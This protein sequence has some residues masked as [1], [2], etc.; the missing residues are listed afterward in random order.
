MR[1]RTWISA[2][3]AAGLAASTQAGAQH[4]VWQESL[5]AQLLT[6]S[7]PHS[8]AVDAAGNVF[9]S[10]AIWTPSPY[11]RVVKY[12]GATGAALWEVAP[13]GVNT[14]LGFNPCRIAV[15]G[16]GNVFLGTNE[17]DE[18]QVTKL[19]GADG[20]TLWKAE[21]NSFVSVLDP[22]IVG[23]AVDGSGDVVVAANWDNGAGA[24]AWAA[25]FAGADG[26]PRWNQLYRQM[27]TLRAFT[28]D[29]AG[30]P[31]MAGSAQGYFLTFKAAAADGSVAWRKTY[32]PTG[33]NPATGT[34]VESLAA[35]AVTTDASGN[36][37]VT[38]YV[39]WQSALSPSP[40]K[41]FQTMKYN[42]AGT[43]LWQATYDGP[44]HGT[45]TGATINVDAQGDV[46]VTGASD[47]AGSGVDIGIVKH[48][49]TDGSVLWSQNVTGP[50]AGSDTPAAAFVD[51]S[52][53]LYVTG[54]TTPGTGGTAVTTVHVSGATGTVLGN[55]NYQGGD[56]G[57]DHG[58]ALAPDPSGNPIALAATYAN[59]GVLDFKVL[60]YAAGLGG[61]AWQSA[62]LAS[63]SPRY[64]LPDAMAL[65]A[66]GNLFVASSF[67]G[68]TS[69]PHDN[70]DIVVARFEGATGT[71][72]WASTFMGPL[73]DWT[74]G[75]TLDGAGNPILASMSTG[76]NG[77]MGFMTLAYRG[78]NGQPIWQQS[79]PSPGSYD[80]HPQAVVYD[81]AGS[82][83][84]TGTAGGRMTFKYATANGAQL[85][86]STAGSPDGGTSLAL[87]DS[88]GL[89]VT[90]GFHTTKLARSNG[91]VLWDKT[92][93]GGGSFSYVASD[94]S[95]NA[96]VAGTSS[97]GATNSY[98]VVKYAGSSGDVLWDRTFARPL[99][100]WVQGIK[101]DSHG[102]VFVIG[103]QQYVAPSGTFELGKTM[104]LSGSDGSLVWERNFDAPAV[105]I[106][107][108]AGLAVDASDNV[109]VVGGT[110][111]PA[112][113]QAFKAIAYAG[114]NGRTLWQH[115]YDGAAHDGAYAS[116]VA[117]ASGAVFVTGSAT[118]PEMDDSSTHLARLGNLP[119]RTAAGTDLDGNGRSDLLWRNVSTGEVYRIGMNGLTIEGAGPV[120]AEPNLAWR[121]VADADFNG[122]GIADLLWRND[123]TGE[124]YFMPFA[125]SGLPAGGHVIYNEANPAWKI[126]ATPDLDGDGKADLLWWNSA[127]GQVY[128]QLF[129]GNAIGAQG[130]VYAEPNTAWKIVATGDFTGAGLQSEVV[131]RN[132]VTGQL[133]M[134]TIAAVDG[135]FTQTGQLL[136]LE[137]N[138]A[139]K[140]V[141][142]PD[143]DGDGRAELLWHNDA[144]GQVYA[145][146]LDRATIFNGG[147]PPALRSWGVT[148]GD[149]IYTEPN[150]DWKIVAFG[151]Y[152]GDGKS[153]IVWRNGSDGRV[154]VMLMR[155]HAI[156]PSSVVYTEPDPDWH[157][158]GA[159]EYAH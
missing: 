138:T 23:I 21:T 150:L 3:C 114:G 116:F 35:D 145:M 50:G 62:P 16:A 28:L 41:D 107:A 64:T 101:L 140:I 136:Y 108:L 36:V 56:K 122:D 45:D 130:F 141:G 96:I 146:T 102:D 43:L 117:V 113:T 22:A 57:G 123:S 132:D 153:D 98:R 152:D 155:G 25:K 42:A 105:G 68:Y 9:V 29:S 46:L 73:P 95:G 128:A 129:D 81:G 74:Y 143:L 13:G 37:F 149:V 24:S 158:L 58:V 10:G 65:D 111:T 77:Y 1:T 94:A 120:Y 47:G 53:D 80:S 127:T 156:G 27:D 48:S 87:A 38:G 71:L 112:G 4:V 31:V 104:K 99:Y 126:V 19:A 70:Q 100:L 11:C 134:M 106:G 90:G 142:A 12:S 88:T 85:W 18:M 72:T 92:V 34:T 33:T 133:F 26:A 51:A 91:A 144:T 54:M 118:E 15:D 75:M 2:L 131:W 93:A 32:A 83:F 14:L 52:G 44:A 63:L 79:F 61:L 119:T 157:L 154:F 148:G 125:A 109:V 159:A 59:G 69:I 39:A 66:A 121:I 55:Q 67:R 5:A 30:N 137:A 139:W 6:A 7:D 17:R 8:M 78:D 76:N 82:V 103:R 147:S 60:K 89:Y 110:T 40:V 124:I 97:D 86:Q 135:H 151:D 84:V 115:A 20:S 49:G